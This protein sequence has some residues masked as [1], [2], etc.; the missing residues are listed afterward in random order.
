ME[1]D[2]QFARN[3]NTAKRHPIFGR[4]EEEYDDDDE[5]EPSDHEDDIAE[6]PSSGAFATSKSFTNPAGAKKLPCEPA[7]PTVP[8]YDWPAT[9]P[10]AFD[11]YDSFRSDKSHTPP[12][13]TYFNNQ[14]FERVFPRLGT[15]PWKRDTEAFYSFPPRPFVPRMNK[16]HLQIVYAAL[17]SACFHKRKKMAK[18]SDMDV[19]RRTGI[20]WRTVQR[21]LFWL[22][23]SGDIQVVSEGRSKAR[24]SSDKTLY[25]VP[26]ATFDMKKQHFTPVPKFV[27][28]HY[29]PVYPRAILLFPSFS[30]SDSGDDLTD[31]G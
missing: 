18:L 21:D 26:L 29:V 5:L 1:K 24:W 16:P 11:G 20:D 8:E 14:V 3:Q 9:A 4:C 17:Y 6:L 31:I 25:S 22:T 10:S 12:G 30:M 27:L 13:A 7:A 23:Q 19:S 28:D 15:N 2:L